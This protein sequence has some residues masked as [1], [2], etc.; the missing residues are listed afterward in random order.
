MDV[1]FVVVNSPSPYN[2][3]LGRAW[4]HGI[5]AV[6]STL[7]QV[8]KFIGWKGRQE[9]LCGDQLQSKKCY[10]STIANKLSLLEVQCVE[11]ADVPIL[12][13]VGMLAEPRNS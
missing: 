12:D 11:I 6:A 2:I 10:L 9:S 8:L 13:E 5:K 4:L 3:I 7:H 1:E